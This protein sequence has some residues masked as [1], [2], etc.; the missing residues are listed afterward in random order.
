MDNCRRVE[1]DQNELDVAVN[2]TIVLQQQVLEAMKKILDA[3]NNSETFQEILNE[4]LE[5][6]RTTDSIGAGIN[7]IKSDQ[8]I[9]DE[10]EA[11]GIFDE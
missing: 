3:M 10:T 9:T 2:Q 6:K 8:T 7:K 5:V 11:Q 4:M 1:A